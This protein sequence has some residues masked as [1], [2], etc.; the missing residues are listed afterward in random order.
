MALCSKCL[1]GA[2]A[3]I[4]RFAQ[5]SPLKHCSTFEVGRFSGSALRATNFG[6]SLLQ[7]REKDGAKGR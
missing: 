6:Y 2:L 7:Q 3:Q 4:P 1:N 5:D